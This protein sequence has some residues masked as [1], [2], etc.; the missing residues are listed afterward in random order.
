MQLILGDHILVTQPKK[1][2][3]TTPYRPVFYTVIDIQGPKVTVYRTTNGRTVSRDA[4]QFKLVNSGVKTDRKN[5]LN[6]DQ[7][8]R[9]AREPRE[10]NHTRATNG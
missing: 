8:Q 9:T 4:S 6:Q 1:N 3:W 7:R 5:T 10:C 2:K